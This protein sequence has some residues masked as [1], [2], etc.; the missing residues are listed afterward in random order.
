MYFL[1]KRQENTRL[2]RISNQFLSI[3]NVLNSHQISSIRGS[4]KGRKKNT[5]NRNYIFTLII[6]LIKLPSINVSNHVYH[7]QFYRT[8][9]N[10]YTN[11]DE[12]LFK[13]RSVQ[14][15]SREQLDRNFTFERTPTYL[16]RVERAKKKAWNGVDR[17][18]EGGREGE[19][20]RENIGREAR[21]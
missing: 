10:A 18:K 8:R 7:E 5:L 6:L 9:Y 3:I 2:I 21:A 19:R 16:E 1:N 4:R 13:V 14:I 11:S 15:L 20:E 12:K 17:K